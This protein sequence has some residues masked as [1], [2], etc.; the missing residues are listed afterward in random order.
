M[1]PVN[2]KQHFHRVNAFVVISIIIQNEGGHERH[3]KL[4]LAVA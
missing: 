3:K 1:R 2:K 4:W